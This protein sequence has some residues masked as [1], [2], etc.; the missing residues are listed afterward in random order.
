VRAEVLEAVELLKK[1]DAAATNAALALLR[2]TVYSFSMR[3]CGHREDAE[4]TSQEVL[5]KSLPYLPRFANPKALGVWLYKV[6]R[7]QCLMRRRK[8]KFAPVRELAL[9]A[10]LPERAELERLLQHPGATPEAA[11]LNSERA[12]R[13]REAVLRMPPP[14]RLILVL[15]DIE[16][17]SSAEVAQVTGLREGTVRVRLHRARL[18]LRKEL[19]KMPAARRSRREAARRAA[20]PGGEFRP[21][22]RCRRIFARLS[23]Y[24]DGE[25]DRGTCEELEK[26]MSGCAPCEAFLSSLRATVQQ[27]RQAGELDLRGGARPLT[28]SRSHRS[29]TRSARKSEAMASDV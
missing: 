8:S 2:D 12:V 23:D 7:N 22:E 24:L 1:G 13:L 21:S 15:H 18:F 26:H 10:L 4:D 20:Q 29:K 5:L 14:Y 6:A 28:P 25:I 17:L 16:E 3:V 11:T 27:C 9:D 19:T